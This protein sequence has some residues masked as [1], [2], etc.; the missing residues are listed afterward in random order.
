MPLKLSLGAYTAVI[1][2]LTTLKAFYQ[3]G[4]LCLPQNQRVRDLRLQPLDEFSTGSWFKPLFDYGGNLALFV[5]FGVLLFMLI[6]RISSSALWGFALSLSVELAQAMF[7]LGR[8]DIDDLIF[9]TL[10]AFLGA[11]IAR[12]LGPRFYPLWQWLTLLAAAVFIV[13][14]IL[15]PR[16]GDPNAVVNFN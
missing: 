10:G 2:A 1:V 16:L 13:L 8:T 7:A 12:L 15:G 14:V 9:N 11:A 6:G 5:P 4:Y 3:I